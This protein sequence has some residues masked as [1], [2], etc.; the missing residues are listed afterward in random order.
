[1]RIS[2]NVSREDVAASIMS[3][4]DR[5]EVMDLLVQVDEYASDYEFSQELIIRLATSFAEEGGGFS[6]PKVGIT[7][8]GQVELVKDLPHLAEDLASVD[9]EYLIALLANAVAIR[10]DRADK[11]ARTLVKQAIEDFE[12]WKPKP[13]AT[14]CVC[15]HT[16]NWHKAANPLLNPDSCTIVHCKCSKFKEEA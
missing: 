12:K 11:E 6:V 13:L 3:T 4:E 5:Q 9:E 2:F 14:V 16:L 1:M 7:M 10:R 15:G 8:K